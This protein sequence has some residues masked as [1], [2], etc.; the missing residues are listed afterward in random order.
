MEPEIGPKSPEKP[1]R[2]FGTFVK[3][4][5]WPQLLKACAQA[6]KAGALRIT[7]TLRSTLE[8]RNSL[9]ALV[10]RAEFDGVVL[11]SCCRPCKVW[12]VTVIGLTT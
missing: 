12:N 1:Q 2:S 11:F 4:A 5:P 6:R 8:Y 10:R 3:Q 7:G 9:K